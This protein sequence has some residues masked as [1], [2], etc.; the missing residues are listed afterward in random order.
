MSIFKKILRYIPL[1]LIILTFMSPIS[2]GQENNIGAVVLEDYVNI[3]SD[4]NIESEIIGYSSLGDKVTIVSSNKEW[5]EI[6]S[7]KG[8]TGWIPNNYL[9]P[10][11][12]ESDPIKKGIVATD[13]LNLREQPSLQSNIIILLPKNTPVIIK[14]SAQD[15]YHVVL[16]NS[17]EGWVH[18]S[19]I[20]AI[21]N[22]SVGRIS[23]NDVNLRRSPALDS[24][25]IDKL[26]M[27]SAVY[28]KSYRDDW[29]EIITSD[30]KTGWI[31]KD[32][33]LVK[34]KESNLAVSR[35]SVDRRAT[36]LIEFAKTLLGK[37]YVYGANGPSSFDC[38]GFTSYVFK[39]SGISIPRTSHSQS[40]E[41]TTISKSDLKMGDLVFFDTSGSINGDIT[42]VGIYIENGDFIHASSGKNAK[43]VVIS[44]LY[45]GYYRDRFVRGK[46]IF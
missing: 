31:Y 37:P 18:S 32:Y 39:N 8:L 23:G 21:P 27:N 13:N 28:I 15:W 46:R 45:E 5:Y 43:R 4:S 7:S 33:I 38:S 10:L 9:I 11:A 42:H 20:E 36:K 44:T 41:G 26:M 29:Y 1:A 24:E 19:Y 16:D 2:F 25:V 30:N 22:Y 14:A 3:M 35:S 40:I 34:M 6:K 12:I 17:Q